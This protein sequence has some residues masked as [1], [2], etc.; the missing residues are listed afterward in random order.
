MTPQRI[1]S[2]VYGRYL[3]RREVGYDYYPNASSALTGA[4]NRDLIQAAIDAA[5]VGTDIHLPAG[6]LLLDKSASAQ[7]GSPSKDYCLLMRSGVRLVGQGR[8]NTILKLSDSQ[9]AHNPTLRQL[10]IISADTLNTVTTMDSWG[11]VD[12]GFDGNPKNQSGYST[13]AQLGA[14]LGIRATPGAA[15][16]EAIS[17]VTLE[18]LMFKDF[19]GNPINIGAGELYF[20]DGVYARK[21]IAF[22]CGEGPQ[23]IRC[24][25]GYIENIRY[26][27]DNPTTLLGVGTGYVTVGDPIELSNCEDMVIVD[28]S[29]F[30]GAPTDANGPWSGAGS[31][32]DLFRSKRVQ[33]FG[34]NA[35]WS[36]GVELGFT[37]IAC[38]DISLTGVHLRNPTPASVSTGTTGISACLGLKLKNVIVEGYGVPVVLPPGPW[39]NGKGCSVDFEGLRVK[40][41]GENNNVYISVPSGAQFRGT[42]L[43][44]EP[45]EYRDGSLTTRTS[46]T[47]GTI[48]LTK[49]PA[50]FIATSDTVRVAWVDATGVRQYRTSVVTVAGSVL[51]ITG[52]TGTDLPAAATVLIV[53]KPL[54]A[55]NLQVGINVIYSAF[56]IHAETRIELTGGRIISPGPAVFV[57][58]SGNVFTPGGFIKGLDARFS[59]GGAWPF[60]Q[61]NSGTW[62]GIEVESVQPKAALHNP[63]FYAG[64]E[65]LTTNANVTTLTNGSKNQ[66]LLLKVTDAANP[67]VPDGTKNFGNTSAAAASR[68]NMSPYLVLSAFESGAGVFLSRD[69]AGVYQETGRIYPVHQNRPGLL[70]YQAPVTVGTTYNASPTSY[71]VDSYGRT[72]VYRIRFSNTSASRTAGTIT[73]VAKRDGATV[74]T[75][76]LDGTNPA[77]HTVASSARLGATFTPGMKF[78]FEITVSADFANSG[79]ATS[80]ILEMAYET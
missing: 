15:A 3:I 80:L 61:G 22:R 4:Q 10:A 71:Q 38:E 46:T 16:N 39:D 66:K 75:V 13:Y 23:W 54:I 68:I 21:I 51:T 69:D 18:G 31:A 47:E 19:F 65:T 2:G 36:N 28:A 17:N 62:N 44:I 77:S 34:L 52:G 20:V 41:G 67:F 56:G 76:I 73:A 27:D 29:V 55:S 57:D 43:Q 59:N 40:G 8:Y 9:L 70:S 49:S 1:Q 45:N 7:P 63:G 25:N 11:V 64:C 72:Q 79:G 14:T 50:G 26:V 58:G 5:P 60:T 74:G 35:L 32:I 33:V 6:T 37:T 12:I 53:D 30:A 48:T 78:V 42:N 24:K